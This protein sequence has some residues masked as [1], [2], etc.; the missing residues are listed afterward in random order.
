M[1]K[2]TKKAG[3]S[4]VALVVTIIILIILTAAVVI[5]G[6]NAPSD[7]QL[8]IFKS[9]VATV[10]DAV[11]VKMLNNV[12][13]HHDKNS[14]NVKWIGVANEYEQDNVTTDPIF[15][16]QINGV[17]VVQL[18]DSIKENL[19]ISQ[20]EFDKYYVDENGIVYH[21]GFAYKGVTYYN[22]NTSNLS[23]EK[24]EIK[25]LPSKLEYNA[26]E[27]IDMAGLKVE[28]TYS[29][30]QTKDVTE[31]VIFSPSLSEITKSTGTKEVTVSYGGVSANDKIEIKVNEAV[32][33]SIAITKYPSTLTYYVGESVDV[34]GIEVTATYSDG[35]TGNISDNVTFEPS[36]SEVT[37]T[38]GTKEITVKYNTMEAEEKITI[39]VN[40]LVLNSIKIEGELE[41]TKYKQGESFDAS[42][43]IVKAVYEG[44]IEK[45]IAKYQ[46]EP[47]G[48]LSGNDTS[49][50][51]S[52]TEN[53][54]TKTVSQSIKVAVLN[55][56]EIVVEPENKT[57]V[58]GHEF[59]KSTIQVS[60]NY[61]YPKYPDEP[62]Y[63]VIVEDYEITSATKL[64][65]GQTSI[66][67]E[68]EDGEVTVQTSLPITVTNNVTGIEVTTV[69][70]KTTYN[71]GD[72]FDKAGMV[73]TATYQD[74]TTKTIQTGYEVQTE[75][76]SYTQNSV[77]IT[78]GGQSTSQAII[79]SLKTL[80]TQITKNNYGDN[81]AYSTTVDG[82]TYDDWQIL[83]KGTIDNTEYIYMIC[84]DGILREQWADMIDS[85]QGNFIGQP[86]QT[87]SSTMLKLFMMDDFTLQ[88]QGLTHNF[89]A[90]CF[91]YYGD[92]AKPNNT[93]LSSEIMGAIASPTLRL[94]VSSWNE[95][96]STTLYYTIK[97]YGYSLNTEPNPTYQAWANNLTMTHPHLF[98]KG[99]YW[100]VSAQGSPQISNLISNFLVKTNSI[101]GA[102]GNSAAKYLRPVVCMKASVTG[103]KENNTWI[104]VD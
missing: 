14:E 25:S 50:T 52:Y 96:N 34:T 66:D 35:Q 95:I 4:L 104:L 27:N 71:H 93:N 86:F 20:E 17:D 87:P 77:T 83:Y 94:F 73:I 90:E 91:N 5:T 1:G 85:T 9:N 40:E 49:V 46:I 6:M 68:Y 59:D 103:Y 7:A 76:L 63:G 58:A 2:I 21:T 72:T 60:A 100:L 82:V 88:S 3:I 74:G 61:V 19:S 22:V 70:T 75:P 67:L 42:G 45:S 23:V 78:Y 38:A 39:T 99:D 24:V 30:G 15:G 28:A 51:I 84:A 32:I 65:E 55:S 26:G 12:L 18:D 101:Q 97:E 10:Q 56:L 64:Q 37:K 81:I 57:Y 43:I 80:G 53:E 62:G 8:A 102:G 98:E 69:P 31:S 47:N 16:I 36:L 13:E 48:E 29:D 11:T 33:T 44:G 92:F 54:V 89:I 41:K 79:V